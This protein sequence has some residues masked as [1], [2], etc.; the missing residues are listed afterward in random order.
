MKSKFIIECYDV[1]KCSWL[2]VMQY[3]TRKVAVFK[4]NQIKKVFP[5][6]K[7]RLYEKT[8]LVLK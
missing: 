3:S 1:L 4:Y 7:Y 6:L 2:P 8:Y 5:H